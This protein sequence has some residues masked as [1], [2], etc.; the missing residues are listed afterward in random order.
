MVLFQ[1]GLWQKEGGSPGK[2]SVMLFK[3]QLPFIRFFNYVQIDYPYRVIVTDDMNTNVETCIGF[4]RAKAAADFAEKLTN[5]WSDVYNE[6]FA[7]KVVNRSDEIIHSGYT[8]FVMKRVV[9]QTRI[10]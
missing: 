2:E 9:E 10:C 6:V 5:H 1:R 3:V 7:W 8:S 4:F